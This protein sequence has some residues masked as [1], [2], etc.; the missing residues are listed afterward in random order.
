MN[1][2]REVGERMREMIGCGQGAS[3][4]DFVEAFDWV[5]VECTGA[6][7]NSVLHCVQF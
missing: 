2:E 1:N 7:T 6:V 3:A 4:K 5:V